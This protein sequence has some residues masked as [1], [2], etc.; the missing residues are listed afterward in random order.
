MRPSRRVLLALAAI[1]LLGL[2]LRL[3]NLGAR[4]MWY[5]EGFTLLVA[6]DAPASLSVFRPGEYDEP[7]MIGAVAA[8]GGEGRVAGRAYARILALRCVR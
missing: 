7:P 6:R 2:G 4:S 5:D 8:L 1:L 3:F